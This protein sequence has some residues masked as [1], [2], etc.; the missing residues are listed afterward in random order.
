MGTPRRSRAGLHTSPSQFGDSGRLAYAA[1]GF[2]FQRAQWQQARVRALNSC[3]INVHFID[4]PETCDFEKTA[5]F[6]A[7]TQSPWAASSLPRALLRRI[8]HSSTVAV[9]TGDRCNPK[10]DKARE[11]IGDK[12][13]HTKKNIKLATS[14]LSVML[15]GWLLAGC[16]Q[17]VAPSPNIFQRVQGETPAPP[18]TSDFFGNCHSLLTP[19]AKGS[20]QQEMLRYSNAN[21]NWSTYNAI[22]IA[23]VS[24]QAVDHS[25]VSAADQQALCNYFDKALIKDLGKNFTIVDQPGL[26][27]AKLSAALTRCD[28]GCPGL[29]HDLSRFTAGSD[30]KS[31]KNGHNRQLPICRFGAGCSQADRFGLRRVARGLGGQ[32]N[33]RRIAKGCGRVQVGGC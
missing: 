16:S 30:I 18:P 20:D 3:G 7:S 29:A 33:G 2:D 6:R 11:K 8:E 21:I 27:V 12:M 14:L 22:I 26:G 28:I 31:A 13:N 4:S 1:G 15:A 24:F 9:E 23:P 19:P 25:R 10:R 5:R 17:T 32:A